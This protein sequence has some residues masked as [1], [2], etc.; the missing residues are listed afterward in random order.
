MVTN[1]PNI[2]LKVE[3]MVVNQDFTCHSLAMRPGIPHR[4][5]V[6][7]LHECALGCSQGIPVSSRFHLV[8]K[9]LRA[10]KKSLR[11]LPHTM[12]RRA[13]GE[14]FVIRPPTTSA[15]VIICG[16]RVS[17]S[18]GL[19]TGCRDTRKHPTA[20]IYGLF[21]VTLKIAFHSIKQGNFSVLLKA[22][23]SSQSP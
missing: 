9:H 20:P 15:A 8:R 21:L 2:W 13:F 11:G 19:T 6:V 10:V 7:G 17:V 23:F 14:I 16:A 12:R 1:P 4:H 22:H 18:D 3:G 5:S